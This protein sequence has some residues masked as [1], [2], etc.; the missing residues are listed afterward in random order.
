MFSRLGGLAYSSGFLSPSLLAFSLESCIRVPLSM[1]P[2]SF[3]LLAWA[4]FPGYD[5]VCF[6]FPLPYWAIPFG[7]LA[8][9]V[10]F[11]TLYDSIVH[12][13]CISIYDCIWV[14]VHFV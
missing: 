7:K 8:M 3:L 6:T 1:Y 9:I 13:V 14:I 12:D 5:N 10:Y 2:L 4:M 11:L